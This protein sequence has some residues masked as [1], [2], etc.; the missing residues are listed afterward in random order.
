MLRSLYYTITSRLLQI[1]VY[2][3]RRSAA[4]GNRPDHQ[5]LPATRIACGKHALYARRVAALIG[6]NAAIACL[7][8]AELIE[9]ALLAARKA[10]GQK[11]QLRRNNALRPGNIHRHAATV[12][13]N[14]TLKV[15]LHIL[16]LYNIRRQKQKAYGILAL[17]WQLYCTIST[18]QGRECYFLA[19]VKN[20]S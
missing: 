7:R 15:T 17:L 10:H 5:A 9:Q 6:S 3:L 20:F 13:L 8:K 1:L 11:H 2:S 12:S 4:L 18:Q 19:K 14:N 16:T